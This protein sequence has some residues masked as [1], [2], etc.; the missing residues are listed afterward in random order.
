MRYL[1]CL[2]LLSLSAPALAQIPT[3]PP[4]PDAFTLFV[5]RPPATVAISARD[6]TAAQAPCAPAPP[7]TASTVNPNVWSWQ[8]LTCASQARVYTDATYL[9]SL[10]D[11]SYT[12]T[13]RAS[14]AG[15]AGAES[16][17]VPFSRARPVPPSVV[18]LLRIIQA[19]SVP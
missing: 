1:L 4:Q 7:A 9:A 10:P 11:G 3:P 17:A 16:P 14:A 8:D 15:L 6:I 19:A 18:P 5:Y 12:G 2:L 13:V